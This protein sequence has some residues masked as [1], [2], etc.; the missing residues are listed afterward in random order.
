[1]KAIVYERYGSPGV[2]QY[3]EIE[4][5]TPR[6]H[7]VLIRGRAASVNPL[8]WVWMRGTPYI[9][10]LIGGLRKPRDK[11][12]GA[13]IAGVVEAVGRKVTQFKP[14]DE[15]F[16]MCKGAFAEFACA[17]ESACALKPPGITFQQAAALPVAAVSALQ[18]LR[19][20]GKLQPGQQV[21]INGAAGG[22]GSFA[23]QIAKAF[24]A[25][26]TG[27]CS[28]RNLGL[29]RSLGADHVLDYTQ[30]D[31]TQD[32]QRYDLFLDCIGN[33]P[34]LA[35]RRILK[36]K[37][38]YV[39]VGG[40]IHNWLSPFD[41]LLKTIVLSAFVSQNFAPFFAKVTA[42]DLN[43]VAQLTASGK[44]TPVI[45]KVYPLRE[46]PDAIRSIETRHTRGKIVIA[47]DH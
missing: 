3:V 17:P 45:E 38:I 41:D 5:P 13:D 14:G 4:R 19:D 36:P 9:L 1:M 39:A 12:T 33:H 22:V 2:L 34:L 46:V 28:T 11:R 44:V 43:A 27:V 35:C 40:P 37:G 24:G 29:V 31:I 30:Q 26:V 7:E 21:L 8:D 25:E 16:G 18:S 23:V 42:Q 15:V 10:R 20:K 32:A 47:L 6:D